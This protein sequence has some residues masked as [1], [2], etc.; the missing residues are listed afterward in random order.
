MDTNTFCST[1]KKT[2]KTLSLSIAQTRFKVGTHV[3]IENTMS[4]CWVN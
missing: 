2:G 4:I 1:K 3:R